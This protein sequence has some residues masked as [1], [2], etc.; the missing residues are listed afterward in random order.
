MKERVHHF[1]AIYNLLGNIR[2]EN[3]SWNLV[4]YHMPNTPLV[5]NE[6]KSYYFLVLKKLGLQ[7][8][9]NK[10]FKND[11]LKINQRFPKIELYF[12]TNKRC[13]YTHIN[14]HTYITSLSGSFAFLLLLLLSRFSHV[15]LCATPQMAAHQAPLSL[16]FSGQEHWSGL[17]FPSPVHESEK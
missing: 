8:E 14:L 15:R 3:L 7:N 11:F 17:P 4:E 6:V 1:Q 9:K 10:D 16:G 2:Q 12:H 5:L 13:A